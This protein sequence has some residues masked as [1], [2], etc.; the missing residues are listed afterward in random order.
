MASRAGERARTWDARRRESAWPVRLPR[1]VGEAAQSVRTWL[2]AE[3]AP[4]RLMPW[5]PIAF[6]TGIVLYFT[7][8]REP[9]LLAAAGL[10]AGLSLA[11]V[12]ARSRPI[13]FPVLLG[14]AAIA[15]G[16][17]VATLRSARVAH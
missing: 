17:A 1:G 8:E 11:A 15:A 3:A 16:F 13:A 6:G 7:A 10:F 4:G 14:L 12:L 9:S 2:V 5:L